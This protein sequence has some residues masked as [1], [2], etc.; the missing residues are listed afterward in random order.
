MKNFIKKLPVI[1]N[2]DKIKYS[3]RHYCYLNKTAKDLHHWR[4]HYLIHDLDKVILMLFL[5]SKTVTKIHR[6]ISFHHAENVF[7]IYD[8]HQM[9]I[10]W[11]CARFTKPDKPLNARQTLTKYYS[12]LETKVI[13]VI[14]SLGL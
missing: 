13:S 14:E 11:E 1:K 6:K 9:V 12:Y 7:K 4:L 10:D 3:L 5:D 2:F 8:I